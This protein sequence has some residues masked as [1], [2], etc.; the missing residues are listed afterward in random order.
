MKNISQELE[1]EFQETI[2]R[3]NDDPEQLMD[4]VTKVSNA[5]TIHD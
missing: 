4:A 5:N 3:F 2:S 1:S